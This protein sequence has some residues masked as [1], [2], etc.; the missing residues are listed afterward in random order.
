MLCTRDQD[1]ILLTAPD[2]VR[3]KMRPSHDS[4][5]T[6]S[7]MPDE[8]AFVCQR[9]SN[10]LQLI[11]GIRSTRPK[12]SSIVNVTLSARRRAP[13]IATTHLLLSAPG[14]MT[15]SKCGAKNLKQRPGISR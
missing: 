7:H 13:V 4:I 12:S 3:T 6:F 8:G 11:L 14:F 5:R 15:T 9:S 1:L 2:H 10:S